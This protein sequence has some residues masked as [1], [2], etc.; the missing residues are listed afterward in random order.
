MYYINVFKQNRKSFIELGEI[1]FWTATIHNWIP[2]LTDDS[3]KDII[4]NSL[5]YLSQ[6][7]KIDVFAFVVMPNHTHNLE[8]Q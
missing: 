3:N 1:Y 5:D 7:K 2:L 6:K 4:I 8:N